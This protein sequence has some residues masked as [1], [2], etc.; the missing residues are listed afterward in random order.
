MV[1]MSPRKT[2]MLMVCTL[3]ILGPRVMLAQQ[4]DQSRMS[5]SLFGGI[6]Q[7]S[8]NLWSIGP[9]RVGLID[10]SGTEIGVDSFSV[11]RNARSG[12]AVGING[13]YYPSS[14]WG[15]SFELSLFDPGLSTD[16]D[17]DFDS[18][19]PNSNNP[20]RAFCTD[21]DQRKVSMGTVNI[22][23][24][25]L[26]RP[27]PTALASP[28]LKAVVGLSDIGSGST[29]VVGRYNGVDR[30]LVFDQGAGFQPTVGF[31]LGIVLPTAAGYAIRLEIRDQLYRV[32]ILDGPA[33]ALAVA[34]S[35]LRWTHNFALLLGVDVVLQKKRGRRY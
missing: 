20:N 3:A 7:T 5:I 31:A 30:V 18:V 15:Y 8:S 4:G 9:Q 33:D 14:R 25:G 1:T 10:F 29:E 22:T 16:C 19:D 17:I 23:G 28:Y 26:F 34:P 27:F 11:S 13:T 35:S 12:L 6:V 32:R 2:K 21:I 24:A